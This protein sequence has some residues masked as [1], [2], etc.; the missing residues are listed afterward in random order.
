MQGKNQTEN[1]Y[2]DNEDVDQYR[3]RNYIGKPALDNIK[4]LETAI[5]DTMK[6]SCAIIYSSK[7]PEI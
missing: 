1:F 6:V 2:L 5:H 4:E 3:G 7:F